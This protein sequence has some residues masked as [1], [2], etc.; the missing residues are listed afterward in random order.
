MKILVKSI[1]KFISFVTKTI[2]KTIV[3]QT[4]SNLLLCR[5]NSLKLVSH[6]NRIL[7]H[8]Q[9]R[10]ALQNMMWMGTPTTIVARNGIN[11][12]FARISFRL[13]FLFSCHSWWINQR[14]SFHS[15]ELKP[16]KHERRNFSISLLL[17]KMKLH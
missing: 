12:L 10:T 3:S 1:L 9:P 14:F 4:T 2:I 16:R 11:Y 5:R 8:F 6:L 15:F 17:W 7:R 13:A